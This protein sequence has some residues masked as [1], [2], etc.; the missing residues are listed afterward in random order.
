MFSQCVKADFDVFK[1]SN[2]GRPFW[3]FFLI[4]MCNFI[5]PEQNN[6]E[7]A[8]VNNS[9]FEVGDKELFHLH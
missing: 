8:R 1:L 7:R 3:Y 5:F 6:H 2:S 9:L 4:K